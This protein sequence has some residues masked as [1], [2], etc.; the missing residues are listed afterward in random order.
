MEPSPTR[1]AIPCSVFPTPFSTVSEIIVSGIPAPTPIMIAEIIIE[2]T[3]CNLN[4]MISTKRHTIPTT[5]AIISLVGS[6]I[7]VVVSIL[8]SSLIHLMFYSFL[9]NTSDLFILF[10][11]KRLV[12]IMFY[13]E[14]I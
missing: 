11:L 9:F 4:L 2:M 10:C 6:A 7:N 14:F 1:S 3:G 5:A 8:I 12:F 13:P